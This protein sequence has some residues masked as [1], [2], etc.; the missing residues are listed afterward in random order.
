MSES[1][2]SGG[3]AETPPPPPPASPPTGMPPA[4]SWA[5]P[6]PVYWGS[7]APAKPRSRRTLWIAL[8][9]VAVLLLLGLWACSLLLKDLGNNFGPAAAVISAADGQITGFRVNTFN[10]RTTITFQAAQGV[11]VADGPSLACNVVKPTL[12]STTAQATA[13]VIVN[14]AGDVIGSSETP[15]P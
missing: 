7:T 9:I 11:D 14:R 1:R 6:P 13:W 3:P 2:P 10:G 8:G 12:A 4:P 15:C 5:G